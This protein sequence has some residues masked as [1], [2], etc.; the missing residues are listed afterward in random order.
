MSKNNAGWC[1]ESFLSKRKPW[2]GASHFTQRSGN[3]ASFVITSVEWS[4]HTPP[5]IGGGGITYLSSKT[6]PAT[7]GVGCGSSCINVPQR[8][9]PMSEARLTKRRCGY[10]Q[11]P[12]RGNPAL[13]KN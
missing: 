2:A 6:T 13:L 1:Q 11:E 8:L 12:A 5:V 10:F 4:R 3:V 9:Q 7:A